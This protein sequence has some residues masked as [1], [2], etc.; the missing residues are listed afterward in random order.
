MKSETSSPA[1]ALL[2]TK[3]RHYKTILL[4]S[5]VRTIPRWRKKLEIS[6]LFTSPP[7]PENWDGLPRTKCSISS[8]AEV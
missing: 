3:L 4:R 5:I 8:S 6:S 2:N 1:D 7:L